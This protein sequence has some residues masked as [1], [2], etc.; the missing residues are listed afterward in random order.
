MRQLFVLFISIGLLEF[1]VL[2]RKKKQYEVPKYQVIME[3]GKISNLQEAFEL[4]YAI[5]P[6][7]LSAYYKSKGAKARSAASWGNM[8]PD[9]SFAF[10]HE[11]DNNS[12]DQEADDDGKY[13]ERKKFSEWQKQKQNNL[14]VQ[15]KWNV[16][17]WG[18]GVD[19]ILLG[20]NRF[21]SAKAGFLK[22]G[23]RGF[24]KDCYIVFRLLS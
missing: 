7:I 4:G 3:K 11:L 21:L 9:V 17:N 15:A 22:A 2:A 12:R 16:F 1:P 8:I 10:G 14:S 20:R 18:S 13:P 6:T 24:S 19:K 23:K 5:N